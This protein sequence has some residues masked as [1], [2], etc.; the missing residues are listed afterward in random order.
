MSNFIK[1]DNDLIQLKEFADRLRNEGCDYYFL[2]DFLEAFIIKAPLGG[3]LTDYLFDSSILDTGYS[4]ITNT[5]VFEIEG[6]LQT[7]SEDASLILNEYH[8]KENNPSDI[9]CYAILLILLHELEHSFQ[10]LV[11]REL[12][13]TPSVMLNSCYRQQ[14]D[15]M[16]KATER[17]NF[18][19]RFRYALYMT[20]VFNASPSIFERN[21][22]IEAYNALLKLANLEG[23][24]EM[25][26][27]FEDMRLVRALY[28]YTHSRTGSLV[29]TSRFILSS[30]FLEGKEEKHTMS[31]AEKVRYGLPLSYE[32]HDRLIQI[33]G[34]GAT[35]QYPHAKKLVR[36]IQ[37]R[38]SF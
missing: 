11:C 15:L 33:P 2:R 28:G 19:D 26:S 13:Q 8:F 36:S 34:S 18:Y 25:A 30:P 20:F 9:E 37:N 27:L 5:L 1:S 17:H 12:A 14:Y 6:L 31:F 16:L 29:T 22:N 4:I 3:L 35:G 10:G 38:K 32:E 7:A 23:N 24:S 21:A